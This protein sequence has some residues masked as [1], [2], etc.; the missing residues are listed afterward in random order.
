MSPVPGRGQRCVSSATCGLIQGQVGPRGAPGQAGPGRGRGRGRRWAVNTERPATVGRRPRSGGGGPVRSSG[1][2][3]PPEDHPTTGLPDQRTQDQH[4]R[5][6]QDQQTI[7]RDHGIIRSPNHAP[8]RRPSD[9]WTI[10][11]LDHRIRT[12]DHTIGTTGHTQSYKIKGLPNHSAN[13]IIR[14]QITPADKHLL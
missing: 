7:R 2:D 10:R 3:Q 9:H 5:G 11:R 12:T 14:F 6:P 8:G 13:Q 4:T 1:E